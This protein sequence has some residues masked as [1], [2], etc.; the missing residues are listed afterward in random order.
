MLRSIV[1]Y[2]TTPSNFLILLIVLGLCLIVM[3]W[4]RLGLFSGALGTIGL[5]IF[6]YSS[7]GEVLMAPL[8]T[9]FPP[10]SPETVPAPDGIVVVG[11]GINEVHAQH[12]GALLELKEDGDAVPIVG[13]L[14]QRYPRARIV[15]TS[16]SPLPPP[17]GPAYGIQRILQEF[18]VAKDRIIIDA[19]SANTVE[20]VRNAIALI[21]E[22]RK[23]TWWV[24]TS[25][26]RMPRVIGVFRNM[27]MEPVPYPVDFRWIPPFD[28]LYT[29]HLTDGL[30]MTDLASKE[31]RGLA[32]Y[33]YQGHTD[34][35]FPSP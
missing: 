30:R 4:R 27:G 2:V 7:A 13:L 5:L 12:T 23:K 10:V 9:R 29:Y 16:G 34:T 32:L 6:G 20:R 26:H 25:A 21:G 35:F 33:W 22:D 8:V 19:T 1:D 24:I 28:P 3:R 11:S 18:G 31:W 15:V 17:L 14:A